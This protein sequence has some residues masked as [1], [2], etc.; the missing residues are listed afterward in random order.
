MH[1]AP[2]LR[3]IV[4]I[5]IL[6]VFFLPNAS[7]SQQFQDCSDAFPV[8]NKQTYSFKNMSGKGL[9]IDDVGKLTCSRLLKE[10]NSTWL[11]FNILK[12]GVLTFIIDPMKSGDDIDFVL[13][14]KVETDCANLKEIRCMAAGE[15]ISQLESRNVSCKG[16]TGLS[17]QS[18]DEFENSGCKYE[19]DNFLKYLAA[20]KDEEY[21][22]LV[23]NFS[24][25][26]GFSISFDGDVEFKEIENCLEY[27]KEEPLA[28]ASIVPNPAKSYID[29]FYRS[30]GNQEIQLDVFSMEGRLQISKSIAPS[31]GDQSYRL[32]IENM[33]AANYLLRFTQAKYSTIRQFTKI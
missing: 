27:I 21:Y 8:C 28:I 26:E 11:T 14:K 31:R 17:Y 32:D 30:S 2:N 5:A 24:G 9:Q 15:T 13:F 22:L 23:N 6:I 19:S 4:S 3:S 1:Y 29:I 18:I 25:G 33:T 16:A 20:E 12:S 10:S 7:F